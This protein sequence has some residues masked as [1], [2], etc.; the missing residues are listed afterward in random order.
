M[1]DINVKNSKGGNKIN[2]IFLLAGIVFLGI[3]GA[4]VISTNIKVSKMD[5]DVIS[6]KVEVKSYIN[7]EGTTMYSP[8]YY[9]RVNGDNYTCGSNSSSSIYPGEEKDR[10]SVV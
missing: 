10:K 4:I 2:Y 3:L 9:Y 1:Y 6:Y 8:V 7:D 5:S